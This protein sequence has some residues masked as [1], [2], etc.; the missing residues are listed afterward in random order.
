MS[1]G[2]QSL[3]DHG[4]DTFIFQPQRFRDGGRRGKNLRAD[5]LYPLEQAI[6][7][8]AKVETHNLRF[9]F[10]ENRRHFVVEGGTPWAGWNGCLINAEFH[11]E[12]REFP[13]PGCLPRGIKNGRHVAKEIDVN[14]FVGVAGDVMQFIAHTLGIE[15]G[16]GQGTESARIGH[17]DRH[18]AGLC[19]GHG[20]L[21]D[22]ELDTEQAL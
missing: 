2:L 7:R 8:Q 18:G 12:R 16:A 19:A 1:A 13:A 17:G 21:N 3:R 11:I 15:H 5:F 10:F 22:G 6:G 9:E 20:R 14:G 4:I